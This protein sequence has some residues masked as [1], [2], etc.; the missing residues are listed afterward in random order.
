MRLTIKLSIM[1]KGF[2][3]VLFLFLSIAGFSQEMTN[4]KLEA[5]FSKKVDTISG[6]SGYWEMIHKK[7]QLLCI[8]DVNHNR[9][10]IISPIAKT[11][12]LDKD[13]LLDAL[14]AN[15]HSALD[16][17]YA[18]S[19]DVLW[20]VFIH[21]LKEL[22]VTEAESAIDQ[23]ANAAI[24]FGTTFSSTEMIFGGESTNTTIET[25]EE[26]IDSNQLNNKF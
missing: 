1:Y 5:I 4:E 11:N 10:R 21:P 17:K 16:V 7:R 23:V 13:L 26:P 20:S 15:F 18:I 6:Y 14:T 24:N 3:S 12:L 8:T 19:K 2:I 25:P 22:S 9:M